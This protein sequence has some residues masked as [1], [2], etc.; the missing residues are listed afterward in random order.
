MDQKS[1]LL[2]KQ[3]YNPKEP[4]IKVL[5]ESFNDVEKSNESKE[6]QVK[7]N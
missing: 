7:S 2:N 1:K 6:S 5:G 3:K 4:E